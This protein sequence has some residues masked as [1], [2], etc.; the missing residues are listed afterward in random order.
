MK[1]SFFAFALFTATT[2]SAFAEP[3][4]YENGGFRARVSGYG[5]LGVIEPNFAINNTTEIVDWSVRGQITYDL[6]DVHRLGFV[7]SINDHGVD[8]RSFTL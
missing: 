3:I 8:E 1:T 2:L 6:N 4:E 5:N 7:Y